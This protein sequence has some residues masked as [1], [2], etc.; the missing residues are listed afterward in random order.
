MKEFKQAIIDEIIHQAESCRIVS[1]HDVGTA[2]GHKHISAQDCRDIIG[3]VSKA[4]PDYRAVKMV[5]PG[6]PDSCA[7]L[8]CTAT[9]VHNDV[10]FI[11]NEG[12]ENND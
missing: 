6:T 10:E 8:W 12:D 9:F 2:L 5:A 1:L 4:L 11:D 3:A 7:S